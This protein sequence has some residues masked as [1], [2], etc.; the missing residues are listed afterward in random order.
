MRS[1]SSNSSPRV[2]LPVFSPLVSFFVSQGFFL[3]LVF[4]EALITQWFC[5]SAAELSPAHD[6]AHTSVVASACAY[7][8][9]DRIDALG[10]ATA[11]VPCAGA[12]IHRVPVVRA[13]KQPNALAVPMVESVDWTHYAGS[14]LA[15]PI[16]PI[17]VLLVFLI[18]QV[19]LAHARG[20][21]GGRGDAR[22]VMRL[23]S[24][25]AAISL[26]R[27]GRRCAGHAATRK[28]CRRGGARCSS[29]LTSPS[30]RRSSGRL[31]SGTTVA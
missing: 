10:R 19:R 2:S 24:M 29:P 11:P 3:V 22:S 1:C 27:R 28:R 14:V 7:V 15:A 8:S 31:R 12:K 30:S 16:S 9:P 26:P 25:L 18:E 6:S 23:R 4:F 21:P 5:R 17:L 20:G 13:D